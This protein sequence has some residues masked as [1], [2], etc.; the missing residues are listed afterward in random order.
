MQIQ[1]NTGEGVQHSDALEAHVEKKLA[2]VNRR[3]GDRLT[4]VEVFCKDANAGKG[5]ED[6]HCT[7]EARPAGF[8]PVVVSAQSVDLYTAVDQAADKLEKALEHRLGRNAAS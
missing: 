2:D 1:L 4:R 3:C 6:K 5:G 7:M 8:D